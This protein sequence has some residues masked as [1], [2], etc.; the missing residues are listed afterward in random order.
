MK[1]SK[2]FL[3]INRLIPQKSF[4][5]YE[6]D[7]A[8]NPAYQTWII[9]S[10]TKPSIYRL[11][12]SVNNNRGHPTNYC[13]DLGSYA[14]NEGYNYLSIVNCSEVRHKFKYGGT[15]SKTIDIYNLNNV[16]LKDR[17]GYDL[18]LYYSMTPRISRCKYINDRTNNNAEHMKWDILYV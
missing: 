11:S 16:H 4:N 15:Y 2:Y 3:G 17:Y 10:K 9:S 7:N 6:L 8:V 18:C 12:S 5:I 13:L 14:N 1:Y